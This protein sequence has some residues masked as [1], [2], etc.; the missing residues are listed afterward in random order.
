MLI[1]LTSNIKKHYKNYC[2]FVDYYWINF[3]EKKKINFI[4]LPNSKIATASILNK[5]KKKIDIV[6]L[7]GG[8]DIYTKNKTIN[9][10]H[11]I[12]KYVIDFSIKNK[13]PVLGIC[14]GMQVLNLFFGGKLIKVK[15]HMRSFH[16]IKYFNKN[17][18]L[19]KRVLKVSTKALHRLTTKKKKNARLL[20]LRS[21]KLAISSIFQKDVVTPFALHRRHIRSLRLRVLLLL[22]LLLLVAMRIPII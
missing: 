12:E 7:Q 20:E 3:F 19:K 13:L 6:I 18:F 11:A 5:F 21:F 15:N 8:N 4:V 1:A 17:N 22:L 9:K 16:Q 14:R 10:R 2:D